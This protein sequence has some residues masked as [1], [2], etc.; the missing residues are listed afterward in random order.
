MNKPSWDYNNEKG[1]AFFVVLWVIVLLS[2]IV[3]Q[4]CYC[5]RA[6]VN[7]TRSL[8]ERVQAYY[9]AEAG[10]N[11][12][13]KELINPAPEPELQEDETVLPESEIISWR[14]NTDI[15]AVAFS[16]GSYTVSIGNE[17]G[18]ININTAD[19]KTLKLLFAGFN[20]EEDEVNMII[21]SIQDWRDKDDFTRLN[22]AET[23]YYESL[24]PPYACK[25]DLFS[26]IQELMYVKGITPELF[27]GGL[28]SMVTIY[29][30]NVD[31]EAA[32]KVN[33]NSASR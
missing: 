3:G 5:M 28:E 17:S 2:V 27:F 12:A 10:F 16:L 6:E 26:S 11:R 20:L 4:F 18:K 30:D 23:D 21:D 31:K 1:V 29:T 19:T 32:S 15:P 7:I 9:I 22:G 8:K 33:I 13:V 25:N 24:D 14:V